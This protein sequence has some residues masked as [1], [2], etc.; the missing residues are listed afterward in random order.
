M[1]ADI[2]PELLEK[3]YKKKLIVPKIEN[4]ETVV[5]ERLKV[6]ETVPTLEE[7]LKKYSPEKLI[8][9]VNLK[10]NGEKVLY[11][12]PVEKLFFL[13]FEE[14]YLKWHKKGVKII[15]LSKGKFSLEELYRKVEDP[16][17]ISKEGKNVYTLRAPLFIGNNATLVVKDSTLRLAFEPGAPIMCSGELYILNSTVLTWDTKNNRYLPIGKIDRKSYYLYGAQP[18]RPY[19]VAVMNG[20]LRIVS[21]TIK[22]LGYRG[23][24]SSFGLGANRWENKKKPYLSLLNFFVSS[25]LKEEKENS[26]EPAVVLVGNTIENNYMGY[27]SNETLGA[28]VL[29]NVFRGNYQYN[30]DPHDWSKGLIVGYNIFEG[31]HKAH[32]VVFSRFTE[33]KVFKNIC[34]GN[35]GAGIMMDRLSRALIEGNLILGNGIGGISLLESDGNEILNNTVIR[36][37]AYGI[38]VRNSLNALIGGN[39]ILRNAGAG[40]EVSVIDISYQTYRNLYLD[41]YHLA[42][43]AWIEENEIRGN[44]RGE[45]KSLWGGVAVFKNRFASTDFVPFGG[46]LRLLASK[47]LK[48]Q[49]EEPV[50]VPG[51]GRKEWIKREIPDITPYLLRFEERALKLGNREAMLPIGFIK[52][53]EETGSSPCEKLKG[54]GVEWI[55]KRAIEGDSNALTSLGLIL[56]TCKSR[57]QRKEALVLLSEGALLGSAQS[58]YV[59]FL[60]PL[61]SEIDQREIERAFKEAVK[62]VESGFLVNCELW[63]EE[64]SCCPKTV[65]PLLKSKLRSFRKRFHVLGAKSCYDFLSKDIK[66]FTKE[67]LENKLKRVK[68]RIEKK[69]ERFVRFFQWEE[70]QLRRATEEYEKNSTEA[71]TFF[72]RNREIIETWNLVL[73]DS[74]KKD[75][76]L[77]KPLLEQRIREI[78]LFRTEKMKLNVEKEINHFWRKYFEGD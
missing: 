22:G 4:P 68:G 72:E 60:L 47:I 27:Y 46:D 19:I 57:E 59:L 70:E 1:D 42:S 17:L 7:L 51:K 43:S 21:S 10:G 58:K 23:L 78:N 31:A 29:G 74:A 36:N 56:L 14:Y 76:E 45:V 49:E 53:N 15:V 39:T 18:P 55:L 40:I 62:R 65:N 35:H 77:I 33:G 52:L 13:P 12:L 3:F 26:R 67:A 63:K 5:P 38:Y 28:V 66:T 48:S 20:K 54:Q 11:V 71:L 25:F 16:S 32:G 24:F 41:P 69:N 61:L 64:L 30:F 50:V 2:S 73:R 34:A 44:M 9:S 8:E 6:E 37:N 75:F